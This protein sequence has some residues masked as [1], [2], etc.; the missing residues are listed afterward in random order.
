MIGGTASTIS[1]IP[2]L[3]ELNFKEVIVSFVLKTDSSFIFNFIL[4]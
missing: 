2:S 1:G 4:A 3:K